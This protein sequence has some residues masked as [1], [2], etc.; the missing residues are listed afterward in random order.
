MRAGWGKKA[1]EDST[2]TEHHEAEPDLEP[3]E[4]KKDR[5]IYALGALFG[6][7]AGFLDVKFG[8]LLL[9]ALFV[10][11]A[12]MLLGALRP[13]RPWRW[14]L[15]VAVFVPAV[16]CVAYFLLT[17][18]PYRAQIYES[19]LGFLTGIAGSYGGATARR[20]LAELWEK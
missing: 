12:T 1:A 13:Q 7:I 16:Q 19:F 5:G 14:T 3:V 9:T 4:R 17:E 15:L 18:K 8:D 10:L 6:L 2:S 20:G 11:A